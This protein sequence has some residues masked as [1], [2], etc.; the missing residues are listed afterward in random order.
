MMCKGRRR[1]PAGA[2]VI[3]NR[4]LT[5]EAPKMGNVWFARN[6]GVSASESVGNV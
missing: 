1:W 2:F 4:F 6:S 5:G 3:G